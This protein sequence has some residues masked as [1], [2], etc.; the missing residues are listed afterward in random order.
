MTISHN[1]ASG[2]GSRTIYVASSWRTQLR[3]HCCSRRVYD[4]KRPA[5]TQQRGF[6]WAAA[7]LRTPILSTARPNCIPA[8]VSHWCSECVYVYRPEQEHR[9]NSGEGK[10][11][12]CYGCQQF[13]LDWQVIETSMSLSTAKRDAT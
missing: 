13:A 7:D 6:H 10:Y 5:D 1:A 3:Q 11:L 4:V 2:R 8:R 9:L 12:W